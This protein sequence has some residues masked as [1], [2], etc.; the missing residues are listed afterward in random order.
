MMGPKYQWKK[1][2]FNLLLGQYS[3]PLISSFFKDTF[4]VICR[5][6]Q[7][8]NNFFK[9]FLL[10][11]TEE[12]STW[13][14]LKIDSGNVVWMK[15]KYLYNVY[16]FEFTECQ[17]IYNFTEKWNIPPESESYI[18]EYLE[19]YMSYS[20]TMKTIYIYIYLYIFSRST[21]IYNIIVIINIL[22]FIYVL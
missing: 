9:I 16:I 15:R 18:I 4:R 5:N 3:S 14:I 8:K 13:K 6:F 17:F 20:S 22:W 7:K 2:D 21:H 1:T 11:S 10:K 12:E 19:I